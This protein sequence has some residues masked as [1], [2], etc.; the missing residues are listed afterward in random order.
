MPI[1]LL[2]MFL[3]LPAT[4]PAA[5]NP[6]LVNNAKLIELLQSLHKL[7]PQTVSDKQLH[8]TIAR[9]IKPLATKDVGRLALLARNMTTGRA[10]DERID[11]VYWSA[12]WV[13]ARRVA[14][15]NDQESVW[16]LGHLAENGRLGGAEQMLMRTLIEQQRAIGKP[17]PKR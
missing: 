4:R 16:L 15:R 10:E 7:T 11:L 3:A 17:K 13:C 5:P 14:E 1:L 2:T 9:L 8:E 6:T 12:F